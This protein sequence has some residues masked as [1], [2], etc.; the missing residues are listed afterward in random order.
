MKGDTGEHMHV[1]FTGSH[2]V[3]NPTDV[4]VRKVQTSLQRVRLSA[5][6]TPVREADSESPRCGRRVALDLR[7]T[8][9]PILTGLSQESPGQDCL[10]SPGHYIT[11]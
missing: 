3:R 6:P 5:E 4:V 10:P 8:L 11:C 9:A 2:S 7:D 1:G